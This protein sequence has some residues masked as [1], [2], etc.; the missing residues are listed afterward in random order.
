MVNKTIHLLKPDIQRGY[1]GKGMGQLATFLKINPKLNEEMLREDIQAGAVQFKPVL[2]MVKKK[3]SRFVVVE[4][5]NEE[6][7]YL[8]V[9]YLAGIY[10]KKDGIEEEDTDLDDFLEGD[11]DTP[12]DYVEPEYMGEDEQ[13]EEDEW[14]NDYWLETP[15]CIPVIPMIELK[16]YLEMNDNSV[17]S[18]FGVFPMLATQT[19]TPK[20]PYWLECT[21][22]PVCIMVDNAW[23]YSAE[24]AKCFGK[25]AKNRHVYI[26]VI[27]KTMNQEQEDSNE[28]LWK[29]EPIQFS[30]SREEALI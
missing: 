30:Y 13:D 9:S 1:L 26:V 14:E 15:N 20:P 12:I 7:G 27:N 29:P 21:E 6:Q 2:D 22:E 3:P 16:N 28:E 4:A 8:A 25:F 18:N 17:Q 5:E 24:D 23:C 10:N 19:N 11:E